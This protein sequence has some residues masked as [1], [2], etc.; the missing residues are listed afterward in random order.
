MKTIHVGGLNPINR[1]TSFASAL[2]KAQDDDTIVLHKSDTV[3]D[4][5]DKNI[6]IK[7]NGHTL[8]VPTGKAGLRIHKPVIIEN[9]KFKV[10]TR[11]N[12][13]VIDNK[14]TLD[15][16]EI[17]LVG[18]IREFYPVVLHKS[19]KLVINGG[20]YTM[21]ES[22]EDAIIEM[23]DV[24][25]YSYYGGDIH[26]STNSDMSKFFGDVKLQNCKV[27]HAS[28]YGV[29]DIH[30]S[31]IGKFVNVYG[32]VYIKN[33]AFDLVH[34][35]PR[36]KLKKEPQRGPLNDQTD[37]KYGLWVEGTLTLDNYQ[38][39]NV[40]EE[41][42]ITYANKGVITVLNSLVDV[43]AK[44]RIK[45]STITFKDT[46]D[47]TYWELIDT[48]PARVRSNVNMNLDA[49]TAME[50][51]DELIGLKSVKER[52]KSIMN[53][54]RIN[55]TSN[56]KNFSFSHHMI[57]AGDPGVGKTTIATIAAEALFEIGAIPQNKITKVTIDDLIKGYVGQTASNVKEI[58]TEA[59]GGVV[60]IDE[61]YELAVKDGQNSFNSEALSVIIRFM[62]DHRD[63]LVVIAAGYTKEM[64]EFL[65]SNVGLARRFQ[66]V[67]FEDYTPK[68][69]A[70]IF[71]LIRR[72][73]KDEY[74]NPAFAQAIPQL[75]EQLVNL[76]LSIPDTNG[77][78]TNGGNGGLVRNVYQRII[79]TRNNRAIIDGNKLLTQADIE[80]GFRA[81]MQQA[82]NRRL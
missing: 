4:I 12:G 55:E 19:G 70:D 56:D 63:E 8:K 34:E 43:P 22:T 74:E 42:L 50:K 36:I 76:N 82:L 30:D 1:V 2:Q 68:E 37:N 61:A 40:D 24:E 59:L 73:Y 51:L 27:A 18:P 66:W 29:T 52:L 77:R 10:E 14:T 53:T 75:F 57:F 48:T 39:L 54:I 26:L 5:I 80:T 46:S 49:K 79:E 58:M 78:I 3:H 45:N 47:Q 17:E 67:E 11:A 13:L 25:L 15:D 65:A 28:F 21:V 64:K 44:H 33:S 7:G 31:I 32:D 20:R 9:V 41:F 16:V 81:E 23:N 35:E 72:S 62:E 71:E 69:M 38:I 60:F 6:I